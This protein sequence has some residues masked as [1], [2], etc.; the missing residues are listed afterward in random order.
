MLSKNINTNNKK[1]TIFRGTFVEPKDENVG[2][3]L[4]KHSK[5]L[6]KAVAVHSY[7]KHCT[8]FVP[9]YKPPEQAKFP[10]SL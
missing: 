5:L 4:E 2:T 1:T 3:F 7:S 10:N 8:S 9:N 6:S